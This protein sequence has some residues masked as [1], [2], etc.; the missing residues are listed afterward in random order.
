[1]RVEE[2][3]GNLAAAQAE[4]ETAVANLDKSVEELTNEHSERVSAMETTLKAE[5]GFSCMFRN[6]ALALPAVP[7]IF[8]S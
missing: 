3:E 5:V 7:I 2:A 1:M 8:D 4:A 6:P